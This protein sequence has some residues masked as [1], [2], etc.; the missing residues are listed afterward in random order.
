MRAARLV[1]LAVVVLGAILVTSASA[2]QAGVPATPRGLHGFE[3]RPNESPK[4]TFSRT[5]AFA[6]SPVRGAACYEFEL[7]TSSSFAGS[8]VIW[9]NVST[10]AKAGKH[11]RPV[12][13]SFH[14]CSEP[15]APVRR[16]RQDRGLHDADRIPAVSS[17]HAAV[18]QKTGY[19]LYAHVRS[20]T[21]PGR[22]PGAPLRPTGEARPFRWSRGRGSPAGRPITAQPAT[23]LVR[24]PG[25]RRWLHQQDRPH[26]RR[27]RATYYVPPRG[28]LVATVQWGVRAVRRVVGALPNG[29]RRSRTGRGRRCTRRRADVVIRED[30]TQAAVSD[31]VSTGT[32]PPTS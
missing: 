12:K 13:V 7:A 24:R 2:S 8:S 21:T 11:C 18:D 28:G 25:A 22:R 31:E 32:S 10:D 20:V 19:S 15:N 29:C 1:M 14:D 30:S 3:L 9:S 27:R 16:S 26:E 5:P 17:P 23:G 6:W 4:R